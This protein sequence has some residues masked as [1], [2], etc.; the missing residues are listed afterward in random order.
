M[1]LGWHGRGVVC[2]QILSCALRLLAISQ[3]CS[4]STS[5]CRSINYILDSLPQQCPTSYHT[6]NDIGPTQGKFLIPTNLIL[7]AGAELTSP[8]LPTTD[9]TLPVDLLSS[10]IDQ[11]QPNIPSVVPSAPNKDSPQSTDESEGRKLEIEKS[12][13]LLSELDAP[14]SDEG[15]L[16]F[17]DWKR[18]NLLQS[19][20]SAH[21]VGKQSNSRHVREAPQPRGEH[22]DQAVDSISDEIDIQ[23]ETF[24]YGKTSKER[25]NYASFDCAA[26]VLK[27]NPE[28]KGSSS[29]LDENRDRYMLNKCSASNKYVVVEMCEDILVDTIVLANFEFFSSTFKEF[30]ISV[31]DRYPT[32]DRGWKTLGTFMGR[33]T[34]EIQAFAVENPLIWARY[35]KIEFISHYGSEFYCPLTLLRIHGTTMMEEYKNQENVKHEEYQHDVSIESSPRLD[36]ATTSTET[37]YDDSYQTLPASNTV[38]PESSSEQTR[39]SKPITHHTATL[40]MTSESNDLAAGHDNMMA[41]IPSDQVLSCEKNRSFESNTSNASN[42]SIESLSTAAEISTEL[43]QSLNQETN[44]DNI[45]ATTILPEKSESSIGMGSSTSPTTQ[46]SVYKTIMKR[47]SL[48]EANATLSLRYIEEQSQLLRDVFSRME[49]R[50]SQKIDAFLVDLNSTVAMRLQY[51]V[52]IFYFVKSDKAAT[53]IRPVMAVHGCRTGESERSFS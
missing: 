47:L 45:S 36:N 20:E 49:R 46:E 53:A 3:L 19:S 12:S 37:I 39:T 4:A 1:F 52:S 32:N 15:F 22:R 14:S 10:S 2:C 26:A 28:A 31:T 35:V 27:S 9:A 24:S 40:K 17:E 43:P 8:V 34:R 44:A 30:R 13:S 50:H 18:L 33:N 11:P 5:T 38:S 16:S 48:L 25:F 29:I 7:P 21:E 42:Q 41:S 23:D 6:A 51:F